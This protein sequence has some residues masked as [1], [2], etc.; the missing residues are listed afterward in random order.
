M[1]TTALFVYDSVLSF[2]RPKHNVFSARNSTARGLT[3]VT[4]VV[5]ISQRA[6][7]GDTHVPF[8]ALSKAYFDLPQRQSNALGFSAQKRLYSLWHGK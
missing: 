1:F 3:Y 6:V 5:G 2:S 4:L 8:G 7:S